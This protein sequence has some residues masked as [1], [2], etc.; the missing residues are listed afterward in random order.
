MGGG[1]VDLNSLIG[2]KVVSKGHVGQ[3]L[4]V[5]DMF[6]IVRFP[7]GTKMPGQGGMVDIED[8]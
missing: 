1:E 8:T 6:L 2:K 4:R 3:V 5:D 7:E